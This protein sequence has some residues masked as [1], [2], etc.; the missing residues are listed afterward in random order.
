MVSYNTICSV[1]LEKN[2]NI[3]CFYNIEGGKLNGCYKE[4]RL[5]S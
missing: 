2:Y 1:L 3:E 4:A 5:F